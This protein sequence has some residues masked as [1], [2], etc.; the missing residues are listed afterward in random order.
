MILTGKRIELRAPGGLLWLARNREGVVRAEAERFGDL[1]FGLGWAHAHDRLVQMM[2]VRIVGR[3]QA[4]QHLD[5]SP[6]TVALDTFMRRMGFHRDAQLQSTSLDDSTRAWCETYCRG[7]NEYLRSERRP[8]ELLLVGYKPDPWQIEDILLTIKL[9]SYMGLAQSQ[10]SVERFLI[11]SVLH[12]VDPELLRDLLHPH[13]EGF[14]PA[15]IDG[16][17][18]AEPL[19]PQNVPWLAAVPVFR[20]SNNWAVSPGKS[21]TGGAIYCSDPHLECD[22][23]PAVWYEAVLRSGPDYLMGATIPGIPGVLIGRNARVSWGVT[24]GFMDQI[25]YFVED[26]RH[27]SFRR[28]GDWVP[29]ETREEILHV[30]DGGERRIRIHE[31]LHGVL[32][33]DPT[34]PGKYLCR[35]WSGHRGNVARTANC[36]AALARATGVE[37]GMEI[38]RDVTISLNW[39]LADRAGNIGFQQSGVL[40]RRAPGASGLYPVPGWDSA[41]D[42]QGFH[43]SSALHRILNP[44]EGFLASANEDLNPPGGPLA[45]NMPMGAYRARRIREVLSR[46]ERVLVEDMKALQLDL[47]SLQAR[48]LMPHLAPLLPDTPEGRAL[49]AWDFNYG[50]DSLQASRFEAIYQELIQAVFGEVA[51]GRPLVDY[52]REETVVF[53]D[54][55][56]PFDR[57]LLSPGSAW[58]RGRNR[59]ALFRRAIA[60]GLEKTVRPWGRQHQVMMRN[61]FFQGKLPA[62]LGFDRGPVTLSGNRATVLQGAIYRSYGLDCTFAPSIRFIT[63]LSTDEAHTALAGGPSG[64]RTS[65]W[66]ASD[67][68]RWQRGLYKT[69]KA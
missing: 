21:A 34:T 10:Q 60:A 69:L 51:W 38:V 42:W 19:V 57:V 1:P 6:G 65:I 46:R 14:D 2:L 68:D 67:V 47:L 36:L 15:W 39:I 23:L 66:Y 43:D 55:Y 27:G 54:F 18:I 58:Y 16:L 64:R 40:P 61:I 33:G 11:Q 17:T 32:E 13:L 4:A 49:A 28:D 8:L 12:G 59:E 30:R 53:T 26:C 50:D 44:P 31:N 20:A 45:I 3:G 56:A 5:G 62:Y 48:D 37:E 35:A 22:R 52:L 7:V 24:Y 9:V 41:Y 29:F 25:D 63:D